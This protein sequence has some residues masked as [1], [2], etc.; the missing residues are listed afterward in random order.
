MVRWALL[1]LLCA[2]CAC[3]DPFWYGCASD[4]EC[5]TASETVSFQP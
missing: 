2:L 5:E 3:D 1:L 4:A